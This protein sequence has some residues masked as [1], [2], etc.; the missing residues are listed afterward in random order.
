[1]QMMEEL[2]P[3]RLYSKSK[4]LYMPFNENDKK[5]GAS[6]QL[7]T[8]DLDT[9]IKLINIPYLYNPKVF[10]AYYMD[11]NVMGLI[12]SKGIIDE[13]EVVTEALQHRA[14]GETRGVVIDCA[15]SANDQRK[16]S[17]IFNFKDI[18]YYF[19]KII[20]KDYKW[21]TVTV[22]GFNSIQTMARAISGEAILQHNDI[23][24]NSYNSLNEIF[25]VNRSNFFEI[26][27]VEKEYPAYCRN[28]MITLVCMNSKNCGRTLANYIGSVLSDQFT[29]M[30]KDMIDKKSSKDVDIIYMKAIRKFF[31]DKG[32]PGIR[33]L[34]RTGDISMVYPYVH[35]ALLGIIN[36]AFRGATLD[37][38]IFESSTNIIMTGVLNELASI[39]DNKIVVGT[40]YHFIGYNDSKTKII[41]KPDSYIDGIIKRQN[42]LVGKDGV[43]I[44]L[45]DMLYKS[46]TNESDIPGEMKDK[47][48]GKIKKLK[49]KY[50]ILVR[51]NHDRLPDEFYLK[52]GFTHVCSSLKYNNYI[53]SHQPQIVPEH[54]INVHGHIHGIKTYIEGDP[55]RYFD[56]FT[57]KNR[58]GTLPEVD[59]KQE[60]YEED[61]GQVKDINKADPH[62]YI[63]GVTLDL[64]DVVTESAVIVESDGTH[65]DA[66]RIYY[67]MDKKE[68]TFLAHDPGDI[69]NI[70]EAKVIYRNV[71]RDGILTNKGFIEVVEDAVDTRYG[72]VIIGVHPRYRR[73]GIADE[74][75]KTMLKE[76]RKEAPGI[77]ALIWRADAA[78][79]ASQKLA[80]KHKFVLTRKTDVQHRYILELEPIEEF[81][82][83]PGIMSPEEL[84]TKIK[85]YK[86]I[87]TVNDKSVV[88]KFSDVYRTMKGNSF[89]I[90]HFNS[91]ALDKMGLSNWMIIIKGY[92]GDK[93]VDAIC[94]SL[95]TY[96]YKVFFFIDP[97]DSNSKNKPM[98]VE[99]T[100]D[101]RMQAIYDY[102]LHNRIVPEK[103][104]T[105]TMCTIESIKWTIA[106]PSDLPK[107]GENIHK[108]DAFKGKANESA[109]AT[110]SSTPV[111][112]S[113]VNRI[114]THIPLPKFFAMEAFTAAHDERGYVLEDNHIIDVEGG[115]I[116]FFGDEALQE[117]NN[118]YDALLKRY[119]YKQRM[120]TTRYLFAHYEE[121]RKKCKLI[122]RMY[123][124]PKLYK[125]RNLYID[126]SYYNGLFLKNNKRIR[127]YGIKMYWDFLSRLLIRQEEIRKDYPKNTIL[128]P[129]FKGAWDIKS[130]TDLFDYNSNINPISTIVRM[131]MLSPKEVQ[132]WANKKIMFVGQSG[133][134]F[135]DFATFEKKDLTR[136][137]TFITKL[138]NNSPVDE[139]DETG[140]SKG[141]KEDEDKDSPAVITKNIVDKIEKG[142]GVPIDDI[143]S[144][145]VS[146]N[147]GGV[148]DLGDIPLMRIR[149]NPI[150]VNG[151]GDVKTSIS[152]LGGSDNDTLKN[153]HKLD[154]AIRLKH[155]RKIKTIHIN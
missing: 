113:T 27:K 140:Y 148:K 132:K 56:A 15:G 139:E 13:E 150:P 25:V 65:A 79:T 67:A 17:D 69:L 36:K 39:P 83:I 134:F 147:N 87:D 9:S 63:P 71:I 14:T 123:I 66:I 137:K 89:D 152:V 35:Y 49:G 22:Y 3:M 42:E 153:I 122:K 105:Q 32:Y 144:A 101:N 117:A 72:S 145:M 54:M 125:A 45:G 99:S 86:L 40:D 127:N 23:I 155:N 16:M 85:N 11:S 21:P 48:I 103:D 93:C 75:I 30:E 18:K 74:L 38:K 108:S 133:Y 142:V 58:T 76:I 20:G 91:I 80:L 121:V 116:Y 34:V 118:S 52:C 5:K 47:A 106:K 111:V 12:D 29:L 81:K 88:R 26:E 62:H 92:V 146:A 124:K 24:A 70:P 149:S 57:L 141:N 64:D 94:L 41:M 2:F 102:V 31:A 136:F 19:E 126:L 78:N 44:F 138:W 53:F 84:C 77:K 51:G 104:I 98:M 61:I 33:R 43:F 119:L 114:I 8:K 131:M 95:Y 97:T 120:K 46:F 130:D 90:A 107:V 1:M 68:K 135:V 4:R 128:I 55:K 154:N 60:K 109:I 6:I 50:K 37:G 10:E 143:S 7:L 115:A 82:G 112:D 129:V 59:E 100:S 110:E 151:N 28:A 73:Q 96:D